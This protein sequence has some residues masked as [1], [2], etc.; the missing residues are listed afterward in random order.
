MILPIFD[1]GYNVYLFPIFYFFFSSF[2]FHKN[3]V[4]PVLLFFL[5][6]FG[7]FT[8]EQQQQSSTSNIAS[9][10]KHC[11]F[12]WCRLVAPSVEA[13]LTLRWV[14]WVFLILPQETAASGPD[15]KDAL[16]NR[17]S[18]WISNEMGTSVNAPLTS[19]SSISRD[20]FH[21]DFWA[22]AWCYN[23]N[24]VLIHFYPSQWHWEYFNES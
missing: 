18:G 7:H 13:V 9:H 4:C 20:S 2:V 1:V 23:F 3:L 22:E 6:S 8:T 16:V 12:T 15:C 5:F 10:L 17:I 14:I 21:G 24:T 11:I 19:S